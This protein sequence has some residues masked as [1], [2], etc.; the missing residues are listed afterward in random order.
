MGPPIRLGFGDQ[1]SMDQRDY[2]CNPHPHNNPSVSHH[3]PDPMPPYQEGSSYG[4]RA[5]GY[6]YSNPQGRGGDR[7]RGRDRGR[8]HGYSNRRGNSDVSSSSHLSSRKTQVAPAVPSFGNPLPL[9]PPISQ[10]VDKKPGKKKKRR[11]NQ[12]GLTPKNE[13]HVSSSEEEDADE[14]LKLGAAVGPAGGVGQMLEFTYKGQTSSLQSSSDIASWIQER[15]K[16]FP[17]AARRAENDARAEKL[18]QER[19]QKK[20]EKRHALEAE[21][22]LKRQLR[23]LEKDKQAAT[24][25]A[26]LKV[27]KLR[28]KLEKEE[29]RVAK[30]EAKSL[31]RSAPEAE[32][33][34]SQGVKRK[35]GQGD[36]EP[37]HVD[38]HPDS[39]VESQPIGSAQG[40]SVE[41]SMAAGSGTVPG[42]NNQPASETQV[43]EEVEVEHATFVPGPLTPTSQESMPER[44][45]GLGQN[46][47]PATEK[48]EHQLQAREL[49][50]RHETL[51]TAPLID[52]PASGDAAS[53][54]SSS[55]SVSS[56]DTLNGD[57]DDETS[58]SGSSSAS[59]IGSE[60]PETATSRRVGTRKVPPPARKHKP[61]K[62]VCR[63]FL[64]TGRC[65]RGKRCRWRHALPDRG[66]KKVSEAA[67]SRPERKSLHQRLLEQQEEN[68]K[69]EKKAQEEHQ[70]DSKDDT[71]AKAVQAD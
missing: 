37:E 8:G 57:E 1:Q 60:G 47:K 39:L 10:P 54:V 68:E 31:K 28:R 36:L 32:S 35:R 50:D 5:G 52:E 59:H 24:E 48:S 63:D 69:A 66:E 12:L 21:R 16:R 40:R 15:K 61:E 4:S 7:G 44:E 25:K 65:R 33:N 34:H 22:L 20:E 45:H 23:T 11:I 3:I 27:E 38:D 56:D 30:A 6:H 53:T 46:E 17:T 2:S 26:K 58:S 9:K 29:R 19:E 67:S 55:M 71:Q 14:E 49:V 62:A 42:A 13:E 70:D 41:V 64:R 43:W 18:Q 51:D